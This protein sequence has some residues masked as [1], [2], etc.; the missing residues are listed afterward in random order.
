MK[1]L[2]AEDE[3]ISR[4]LMQDVMSKFGTCHLVV[5]GREA[6]QAFSIALGKK[7]PF[8]LVCLDIMMPKMDGQEAL[9]EIRKIE[10]ENGVGGSDM[11]KVI[12]TTALTDPQ[13]I[14]ESFI[15]GSC[16]AYLTKPINIEKIEAILKKIG[17][18]E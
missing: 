17:I 15:K 10:A 2:I 5:N 11:A 18:A 14:M 1:I 9:R 13:N 6:V 12:M 8:D 3:F 7:E 16:E 4:E